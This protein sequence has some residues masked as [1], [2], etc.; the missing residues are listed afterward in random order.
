MTKNLRGQ[1]GGSIL[2]V[3]D[4]TGIEETLQKSARKDGKTVK[5]TIDASLQKKKPM[6]S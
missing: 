2:I 5:L 1:D 6:I 4:E 3:H